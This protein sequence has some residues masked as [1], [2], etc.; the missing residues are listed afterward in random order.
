MK[1]LMVMVM[2]FGFSLALT[3]T[4][5]AGMAADNCGCGLGTVLWQNNAD[6]SVLSQTLQVTTNGTFANML[7]GITSG[8]LECE[9]P[10][11]IAANERLMEFASRNMDSLAKDMAKGGGEA[12]ETLAELMNVPEK[13]HGEFFTKLQSNFGDIF[14]T[15]EESAATILDRIVIAAN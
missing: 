4:A 3:G 11:K 6:D 13:D 8:T 14:V 1:K 9:K 7:F 10:A 5:L 2:V 12:L 15:G